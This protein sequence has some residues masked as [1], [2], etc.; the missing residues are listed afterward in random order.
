MKQNKILSML[1]LAA[2]AGAV[3]SGEFMTEKAVKGGKA[4]LVIVGEDASGNTKKMFLNMCDFYGVPCRIYGSKEE[5][6]HA[7]G[8]EMRASVAVT[9]EGFANSLIGHLEAA[10]VKEG[11][12]E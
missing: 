11:K 2:R 5:L 7:I 8:K 9:N 3:A 10:G 12:V 4:W 1:G 6:G